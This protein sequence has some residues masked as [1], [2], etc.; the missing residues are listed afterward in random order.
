MWPRFAGVFLSSSLHPR[1]SHLRGGMA[2]LAAA[3]K[4]FEAHL[5][6]SRRVA[7]S[8]LR[9]LGAATDPDEVRQVAQVETWERALVFDPSKWRR[10]PAGDPFEIFAYPAVYGAC[11]AVGYRGGIGGRWRHDGQPI[12][13]LRLAQLSDDMPAGA[14]PQDGL[15]TSPNQ[16]RIDQLLDA[17]HRSGVIAAVLEELPKT[18]RWIVAEHYLGGVSLSAIAESLHRSRATVSSLH[19]RSL[20]LLRLALDRRGI[21]SAGALCS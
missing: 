10:K 1:G 19:A 7:D 17:A 14:I 2:T 11:L 21:R 8:A 12:Q 18:E 6:W 4:L 9:R 3:R 13:I 15:A 20:H 16:A 5:P